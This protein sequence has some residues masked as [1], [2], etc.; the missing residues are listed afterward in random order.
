[1]T[2]IGNLWYA[3]KN[4]ILSNR[5][6]IGVNI[7]LIILL[8]FVN[9]NS[10]LTHVNYLYF[11]FASF[12]FL[13]ILLTV[14]M[15]PRFNR[16]IVFTLPGNAQLKMLL[17]YS[18]VAF[19]ANIISFFLYRIDYWFV[20]KYCSAQHLGEYI[21]VSKIVQMFFLLPSMFATVL[22]P[23]TASGQREQAND[24]V[25]TL[26]RSLFLLYGFVCL[27]LAI[28]GRWLFPFVYGET[29]SDM[30]IPFLF[31]VPGILAF[32]SLYVLAAYYAGKD[33]VMVNVKGCSLAFL[34][35]FMGD[36]FLIP[37]YGI[38]AAAAV[39]SLGYVIYFT[40]VLSV[41]KKEYTVP[42][43]SFFYFKLSD[44]KKYKDAF[45]PLKQ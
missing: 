24:M 20:H 19:S 45:K 26:S 5:A 27:V 30:Y 9:E 21:Q 16:P 2:F 33:R 43:K 42:L 1:M 4:F 22:F 13:G 17:S 3:G 25:L 28:T 23:L 40:Y 29:F 35:V 34:C 32:S 31:L 11:Y 18:L 44:L 36:A 8:F 12:L 10:W 6:G 37:R 38:K 15:L 41:F 7:I 39:S 14:L